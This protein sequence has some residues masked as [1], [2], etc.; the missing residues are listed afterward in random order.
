MIHKHNPNPTSKTNIRKTRASII[1]S[2]A[3]LLWDQS[4]PNGEEAVPED[5]WEAIL[6]GPCN[7]DAQLVDE[8]CAYERNL[9]EAMESES[10]PIEVAVPQSCYLEFLFDFFQDSKHPV[11]LLWNLEKSD[12]FPEEG[13]DILLDRWTDGDSEKKERLKEH[14]RA[15]KKVRETGRYTFFS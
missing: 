8:V 11:F 14:A 10:E 2:L 7:G 3:E 5:Q 13:W 9:R 1:R 6:I 15:L 4:K 12:W